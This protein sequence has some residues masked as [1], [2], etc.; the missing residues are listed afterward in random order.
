[1]KI[2]QSYKRIIGMARVS[3]QRVI[4]WTM[5]M[6]LLYYITKQILL[7]LIVLLLMLLLLMLLIK[8]IRIQDGFKICSVQVVPADTDVA[9][10]RHKEE[11]KEESAK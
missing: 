6:S 7:F 8:V 4:E 1:M 10:L 11:E 2:Q 3:N 5:L 9:V